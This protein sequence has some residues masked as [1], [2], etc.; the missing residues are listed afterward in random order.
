[1]SVEENLKLVDAG[2]EAY[3]AHD[4]DRF[5]EFYA[6]SVVNYGPNLPEPSKGLAA[7]RERFETNEIAF[8]D[9]RMEKVRAF[10]Q[11]DYVCVETVWKGTHKGPM[12]GPK[13]ETIPATNKSVQT[14]MT[15]VLKIEEGKV[16]EDH[17]YWDQLATLSQLGLA[18]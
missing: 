15:M 9:H 10:G 1:M 11:G 7:L 18:P 4:W 13:G 16:T 17:G 5:F 2:L 14:P 8:P 3:N 6:E 12:Q